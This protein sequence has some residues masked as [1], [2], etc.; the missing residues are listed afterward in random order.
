VTAS[1]AFIIVYIGMRSI[2]WAAVERASYVMNQGAKTL[3]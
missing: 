1:I 2:R 3:A